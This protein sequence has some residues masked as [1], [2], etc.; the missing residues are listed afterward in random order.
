MLLAVD[1]G[2]TNIEFGL[3]KGDCLLK[4]WRLHTD[5]RLTADELFVS[6]SHLISLEDVTISEING[7]V[8]SCVVPSMLYAVDTFC[9]KYLRVK[10]LVVRPE[11]TSGIK[12]CVDNPQE[13]GVDR[14]ANAVAAFTKYQ[15]DLIVV[16]F[17]T[18]TTFNYVSKRGD[19]MGG[20]IAPGVLISCEALFARAAKLPR[21]AVFARPRSVIAK[22]TAAAINAGAVYGFAGMADG[23]VMRMK[24]EIGGPVK[25]IAT[26]G[27][28]SLIVPESKTIKVVEP[29][30]TLEG[31]RL[32]YEQQPDILK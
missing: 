10:P 19:Y 32:I 14:L 12:I 31:L 23:I 29:Y 13:V 18:A 25:V 6:L 21:T 22:D 2:N 16:D 1:I 5:P 9:Q 15:R 27:L 3:F 20:V 30:L 11:V 8:I 7:V 24:R 28:A 26:G 4:G 17:G